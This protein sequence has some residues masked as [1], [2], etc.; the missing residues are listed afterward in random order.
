MCGGGGGRQGSGRAGWRRKGRS[1]SLQFYTDSSFSA[2]I[3]L[4][5]SDLVFGAGLSPLSLL[6]PGC[7]RVTREV[8][9]KG[10]KRREAGGMQKEVPALLGPRPWSHSLVLGVPD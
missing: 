4:S 6:L 5:T 3:C 10:G 1:G 7:S 9:S 8:D 2:G